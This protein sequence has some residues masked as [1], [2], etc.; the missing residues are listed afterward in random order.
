MTPTMLN[1]L[2]YAS[3]L[4][5]FSTVKRNTLRIKAEKT[6]TRQSGTLHYCTDVTRDRKRKTRLPHAH[7][8]TYC[9]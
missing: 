9:N 5:L 3:T 7:M 6:E 4:C 8:E 1:I 2:Q